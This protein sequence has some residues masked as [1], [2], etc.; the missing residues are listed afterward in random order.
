MHVD[1][2]LIPLR[3][4]EGDLTNLIF[5][6][7]LEDGQ[8]VFKS[9]DAAVRACATVIQEQFGGIQSERAE[10]SLSIKPRDR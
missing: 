2:I 9:C 5:E 6:L 8:V 4:D 3:G 1:S 7:T 10:R